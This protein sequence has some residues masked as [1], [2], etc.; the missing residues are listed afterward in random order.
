MKVSVNW[1]KELVA[2]DL[3][4][5]QIAHKLTMAGLEVE[6]V[7]PVAAAFN[8]IVVAEVKTVAQH[9]NAD[10]LRV[11]EVDAGSGALLQI[12]C[13]APN[14][15]VGM[16]VPC[17][18]VGAV[19]PGLEIKQA[20]LRGVE[21]NGMLCSAK[22]LGLSDDHGGLLA[23]AQDAP[24]GKDIRE[25]L[26]LNDV[27]LTLKM[28]PNR[29]DCLSMIGVARDL[30]AVT[31]AQLRL[32]KTEPVAPTGTAKRAVTISAPQA[33][34]HYLGR[35]ITSINAKAASPEWL[36]RRLERAGFR[37]I[38]PLVDITNF[39]TLERGR[40]MHA[41]DNDKLTGAIKVRFPKAGEDMNLLNEQH[42]VLAPD[43]L[44]IADEAGPVAIGG[45][46]GGLESSVTD[47]TTSIFFEAA[48]FDPDVIKGKTRHLG[49]NSDAAYRFERG[50]DPTSARDG[51]EY[52]TRLAVA[53]CGTADTT[54][55]PITEA[56]GQLPVRQPV[57]VRVERVCRL[58]G[59]QIPIAE[60][61]TILQKLACKVV[62]ENDVFRVTPPSYRFDLNH[63]EDFAEEIARVN[64]YENVPA[65]PPRATVPITAIPEAIRGRGAVRHATAAMGYQEVI[66]YSFVP[67]ERET[68]LM[69]NPSPVR[70]AN[71]IS[72][73][74]GVMRTSL[75][76][77]LIE[78]LQYNLNRGE[79]R[80]KLFEI[81]RCFTGADAD[82]ANQPERMAGLAYGARFP[83]QWGEEKSEKTDFFA[84]KGDVETLLAGH[85]CRFVPV[86]HPALHPGRSAS[87][88]IGEE[89]VGWIGEL[90]PRWQ[91]H[92]GLPIAPVAF[93]LDLPAISVGTNFRFQPI[94]K[95]QAVRRDVALLVDDAVQVQ[96]MID[97]FL[98]LKTATLVDLA[99][100]D[101]YR[102][103]NVDSGKKS[104]A[105]RIVMQDTERTLT[106]M[107][108]DAV[109]TKFVEVMS[110]KFG[111]S[112]R[113]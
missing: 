4:V 48:Y 35:V 87:I 57:S 110:Q 40:P 12:V 84:V 16:R 64:G 83:E 38:S 15:T 102:G 62:A 24:I 34:G 21:S 98:A 7:T 89:P 108:C 3:T 75:L 22:E 55:G 68:G 17:A 63:E 9:P 85:I 29:G 76:G 91:Q 82:L 90:H 73:H 78:S 46:M 37:C 36:K 42:V 112:L 100:F 39:L 81:G 66:N 113:K 5:E 8:N 77:G 26:D 18:M 95:M 111:A 97:A 103:Q 88:Q 28:T 51:I 27:V 10:K 99:L 54:I 25:Y 53:I 107:E 20:K 109:V 49:I 59:M 14:V 94:S 45:V 43:M 92:F 71:P 106:D 60:M 6:D 44:L 74:M 80:A 67:V 65:S 19:L 13:G 58:I 1:L 30:A 96:A 33:C 47:A 93:E 52:A 86:V 56:V 104:L 61:K 72:A 32:P 50:V 79:L 23:L 41:F 11:T 31:G 69:G 70:V 101:V 2:V 105:F